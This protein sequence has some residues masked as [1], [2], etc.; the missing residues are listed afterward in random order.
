MRI[1][2]TERID[3]WVSINMGAI[4]LNNG[5]SSR[6]D[7]FSSRSNLPNSYVDWKCELV[8]FL[9]EVNETPRYGTVCVP[10]VLF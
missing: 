9:S 2:G 5:R 6:K 4:Q 8:S 10:A 7:N 1:T 3:A